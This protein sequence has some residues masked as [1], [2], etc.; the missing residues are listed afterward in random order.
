M[1]N[2]N[3]SLGTGGYLNAT[4]EVNASSFGFGKGGYIPPTVT[5][6]LRFFG[7]SVVI[8]NNFN[9][10]GYSQFTTANFSSRVVIANDTSIVMN[11]TKIG[12]GCIYWNGSTMISEVPC[13][14]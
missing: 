6:I 5:G 12:M 13:T 11:L 9:V 3:L 8:D 2:L 10:T 4:K 1:T 14:Q 7:M